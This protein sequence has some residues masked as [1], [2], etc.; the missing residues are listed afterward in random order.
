VAAVRVTRATLT[1][2]LAVALSL[3][4]VPAAGAAN[5]PVLHD[6]LVV[7][8]NWDGTADVVDPL[9]SSR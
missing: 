8:N 9:T 5:T 6:V 7:G 3:M 2:A 1:A 4:L